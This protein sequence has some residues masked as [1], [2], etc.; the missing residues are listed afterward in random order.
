MRLRLRQASPFGRR[1]GTA[2]ASN[3]FPDP[4]FS[5]FQAARRDLPAAVRFDRFISL[6]VVRPL[7]G[8][9]RLPYREA[10]ISERVQFPVPILM[11]H[12]ITDDP[13]E[14][15]SPYYRVNTS[16]RRFREHMKFLS[17]QGYGAMSLDQLVSVLQSRVPTGGS[18]VK[19]RLGSTARPVIITFD[20]GFQD[21]YT[22]A[23]PI[24]GEFHFGAIVFLPSSLISGSPGK[25]K[26]RQCMNWN[27]VRELRALGFEFGSHTV[28]HPVL[29]DLPW[30]LVAQ[31]L[32]DSKAAIEERLGEAI[33]AFAYPYAFPQA[34]K[35]WVARISDL[36]REAGYQCNVTTSIGRA[37]R[38]DNP[39]L[40][41]RL[42][43]NDCD[44][45]ELFSAKL[46]GAYD[47]MG[48]PQLAMKHAKRFLKPKRSEA[49]IDPSRK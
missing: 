41:K 42:P 14:G 4:T 25:L 21:F 32:R 47:W 8:G 20:D 19:T 11:Y 29:A 2:L 13:E 5:G 38:S 43:V 31:E 48:Y 30:N 34:D 16:P 1:R 17:D 39:F 6:S 7:H 33:T 36:V 35:R 23:A 46:E 15:V 40:L 22:E 49:P 37:R 3:H 18:D 10:L 44:D 28:T 12:G 45:L 24:L 27:E 26:E 9:G